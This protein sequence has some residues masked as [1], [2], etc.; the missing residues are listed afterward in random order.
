MRGYTQTKIKSSTLVYVYIGPY[1]FDIPQ[2]DIC[3]L[4]TYHERRGD[5]KGFRYSREYTCQLS[6]TKRLPSLI[7]RLL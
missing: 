7:N 3:S 1:L 2:N 4:F 5:R 6:P